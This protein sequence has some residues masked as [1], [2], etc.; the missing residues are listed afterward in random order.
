M[1]KKD[2]F[3]MR[4]VGK[5]LYENSLQ[6]I[7]EMAKDDTIPQFD[8]AGFA[9]KEAQ[10]LRELQ[11][12]CGGR[13]RYAKWIAT[14][15]AICLVVT[16]SVFVVSKPLVSYPSFINHLF[17]MDNGDSLDI[18]LS[19]VI[20]PDNW[21]GNYAPTRMLLEYK[22]ADWEDENSMYWVQYTNDAEE[23]IT[24]SVVEGNYS[25][26]ID[27]ENAEVE[28]IMIGDREGVCITKKKDNGEKI[29]RH[30]VW[31]IGDALLSL[32]ADDLSADMLIDIA[33]SVMKTE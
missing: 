24:F 21:S 13:P 31:T 2:D 1:S 9:E 33:A 30:I 5:L 19:P 11:K 17:W 10:A 14:A 16:C 6:E 25:T 18:T 3:L 12:E 32:S 28:K 22:I 8:S 26:T 23:Y 4:D 7:K 15:A 29:H 27:T 20:I